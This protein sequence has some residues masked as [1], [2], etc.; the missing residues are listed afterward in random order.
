M[1]E[2]TEN[3]SKKL[4]IEQVEQPPDTLLK[5]KPSQ[6]YY[7]D[8]EEE[9]QEKPLHNSLNEEQNLKLDAPKPKISNS[10][11]KQSKQ[12]N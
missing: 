9:Q 8:N 5:L 10:A 6:P 1:V 2:E 12:P 11:E 7:S 3:N 4:K